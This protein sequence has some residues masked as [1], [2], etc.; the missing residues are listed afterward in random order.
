M[1]SVRASDT[2]NC[3]VHWTEFAAVVC[4]LCEQWI[5][6]LL[7]YQGEASHLRSHAP[8][9]WPRQAA[10]V[11]ALPAPWQHDLSQGQA[12]VDSSSWGF[13]CQCHTSTQMDRVRACRDPAPSWQNS[14]PKSRGIREAG[15]PGRPAA[16]T[17]SE[18]HSVPV[19]GGGGGVDVARMFTSTFSAEPSASMAS[20]AIASWPGCNRAAGSKAGRACACA[21]RAQ[22]PA[23]NGQTCAVGC[24][25]ADV[26]CSFGA[27]EAAAAACPTAQ[28]AAS[29]ACVRACMAHRCATSGGRAAARARA[30]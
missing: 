17:L 29:C 2:S 8:L 3:N 22:R 20:S 18:G 24:C 21:G 30:T 5:G 9:A 27:A 6:F 10:L 13:W 19:G 4:L 28:S 7:E 15:R 26:A 25:A 14:P 12:F 23:D 16:G 1:H 11:A